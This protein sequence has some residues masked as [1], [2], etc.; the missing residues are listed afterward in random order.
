MIYSVELGVQ[1]FFTEEKQLAA[2]YLLDC[3]LFLISASLYS[4]VFLNLKLCLYSPRYFCFLTISM[5][6][7]EV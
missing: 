3:I 5:K 7:E 6:K 2:N 4:T 1:I